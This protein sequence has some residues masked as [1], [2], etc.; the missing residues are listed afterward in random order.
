MDGFAR[1]LV[2]AG[3]RQERVTEP[4]RHDGEAEDVLDA[5]AVFAILHELGHAAIDQ[6]RLP[7]PGSGEDAADGFAAYALLAGGESG[8]VHGA[9]RWLNWLEA[10][11]VSISADAPRDYADGHALPGQRYERL[12]CLHEGR[13]RVA[14]E[15]I[16]RK[17]R[18]DC[19][20]EWL[21]LADAWQRLLRARSA[22]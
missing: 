2:R 16:E 9:A 18:P 11:P 5:F 10:H 17:S 13:M 3:L 7:V 14:P 12:R 8:T 4:G 21:R 15:A 6:L 20:S 22:P 1:A 19:Q